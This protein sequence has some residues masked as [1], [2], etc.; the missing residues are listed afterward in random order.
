M[1]VGTYV[2]RKEKKKMILPSF[3]LVWEYSNSL[4]LC[5]TLSDSVAHQVPLS[6]GFWKQEYWN[7]LPCHSA[8]DLPNPGLEHASLIS[9]ELAGR[10]FTTNATW[11]ITHSF[12]HLYNF[13]LSIYIIL[14]DVPNN[15]WDRK[16]SYYYLPFM[17][18][19]L[20]KRSSTY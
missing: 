4:Q 18:Q 11:K 5:L 15:L 8:G 16:E 3:I 1:S 10:F 14:F 2:N 9:P 17:R 19:Q 13:Y 20:Q 7:G 6:M 12:L